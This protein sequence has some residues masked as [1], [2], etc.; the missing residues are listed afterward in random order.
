VQI[1]T[2]CCSKLILYSD[3]ASGISIPY[4]S[5]AL[6][7][8]GTIR[9]NLLPEGRSD[10]VYLQLN[11]HDPE[12][13]NSD[14]DIQTVDLTIIPSDVTYPAPEDS[15]TATPQSPASLLFEA[16]SACANLHPDPESPGSEDEQAAP[17]AGG[18][19]TAENMS[20]FLDADGNFIGVNA[21][22]PGAGVVHAREE[23]SEQEVVNGADEP[24][25]TK[26]HRT[27]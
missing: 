14:D 13:I 18:W 2:N 11:L 6:H 1:N 3:G 16:L 12:T 20:D 25:D 26:W 27:S 9:S 10:V 15:E 8:K 19:I 22:G 7:A 5:I 21:L 17:G 23:D 24:D 4:P